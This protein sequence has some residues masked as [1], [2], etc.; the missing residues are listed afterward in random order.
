MKKKQKDDILGEEESDLPINEGTYSRGDGVKFDVDVVFFQCLE[1]ARARNAIRKRPT[2]TSCRR[3]ART[4]R[5]HLSS[6][7]L[8]GTWL[9]WILPLTQS[10]ASNAA[11]NGE[12]IDAYDASRTTW[13]NSLSRTYYP[14]VGMGQNC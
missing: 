10:S 3:E 13:G 4:S 2:S 6:R 14:S 5:P 9:V 8:L 1:G 11:N 12:N 7:Y